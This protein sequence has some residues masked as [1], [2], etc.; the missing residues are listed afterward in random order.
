MLTAVNLL[1]S[2]RFSSGRGAALSLVNLSWSLGAVTAPFALGSLLPV[3]RLHLLLVTVSV[4][5]A[6]ACLAA[7]VN[8]RGAAFA[9]PAIDGKASRRGLSPAGFA[10]FASLLLLYGG[11]ETSISGWITTFG[12]RYGSATLQTSALGATSLWIGITAGRALAP[13][14]LRWLRERTLLIGTLLAASALTAGLSQ[15][16]GAAAIIACAGLLGIA[17]APWFPLVLSS[18]LGEG[19]AAGEV[20]TIIAV[21]GVGAATLPLLL[22]S[23]SRLTGSLRV[24]LWVPLLGL[25]MLLALSFRRAKLSIDSP[26]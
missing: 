14:L 3:V 1:A 17:L 4:L 12:T 5:F 13:L 2:Q 22:G 15:A 6:V 11:V 23:V 25:L 26:L 7:L 18:M 21:S 24:A 16:N 9:R 10:Y 19:A 20:G 8:A